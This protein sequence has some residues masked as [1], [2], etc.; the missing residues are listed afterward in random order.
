MDQTSLPL[1][2][3]YFRILTMINVYVFLLHLPL[4]KPLLTGPLLACL[5]QSDCVSLG[6]LYSCVVY[7]CTDRYSTCSLD[8]D[9]GLGDVCHQGSC[10]PVREL[11]QC[12]GPS[13]ASTE[14]DTGG[15]ESGVWGC[16]GGWCCPQAFQRYS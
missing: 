15:T 8:E 4:S 1:P 6:H 16:C 11:Q 14:C 9:C 3:I 7:R 5:D 2:F 12:T 13:E 10:V